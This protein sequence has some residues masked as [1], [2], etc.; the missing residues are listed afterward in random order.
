MEVEARLREAERRAREEA[1]QE[2]ERRL[3]VVRT[4]PGFESRGTRAQNGATRTQ[5]DEEI[6]ARDWSERRKRRVVRFA[7]EAE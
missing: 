6:A 2:Q 3:A 1:E 4:P 5:V 7:G